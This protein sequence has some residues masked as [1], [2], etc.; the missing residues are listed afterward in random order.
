MLNQYIIHT[1]IPL[2]ALTLLSSAYTSRAQDQKYHPIESYSVR[3]K[4]AGNSTGEK[5][6]FSG[7]WGRTLC[8]KETVEI[9]RPGGTPLR[10]NEKVITKIKGGDQWVTKINTDDNA[11]TKAKSPV[12]PRIY[13][14]IKGKDP[15]E[16]MKELITGSGAKRLGEKTV[17]GEKC[18]EWELRE[19]ASTCLTDDLIRVE[20]TLVTDELSVTET[21]IE[22]KRNVPELDGVCSIGTAVITE[23][24]IKNPTDEEI[25][26]E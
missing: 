17:A 12:F 18:T 5:T 2:A 14:R 11:G 6:E 21:A 15:V 16:F 24:E 22:V 8:W 3:Y 26:V 19:G 20:S 1:L 10:I 25:K 9:K 13:E 7:D 23:T 4:I